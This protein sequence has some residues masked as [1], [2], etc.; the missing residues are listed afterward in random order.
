MTNSLVL[1]GVLCVS[2]A[3]LSPTLRRF[4]RNRRL[5]LRHGCK[6][7]PSVDS[8]DF[9]DLG[10]KAS[11]EH[12][13]LDVTGDLFMKYGTTHRVIN[14]GK[15]MI[16]TCDPEISKAVLATQF[17]KF[18]LQPIRYE[19]AKASFYYDTTSSVS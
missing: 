13:Y 4:F 12:R 16:R 7:P 10:R 17:E 6:D 11:Q 5:A 15:I 3:L 2:A 8:I 18:G 14:S 19:N 9:S 1:F